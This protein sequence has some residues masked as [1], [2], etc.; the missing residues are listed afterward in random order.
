MAPRERGAIYDEMNR[1]IAA[2]HRVD[3][4]AIG[5][6]DYGKPGNYF[7][8]Q[9]DRWT[10]QYQASETEPS[11]RWT[12]DRMAAATHSAGRARRRI[13]HGDF[14]IDNMIFHPTEPRVLAVLDWELSTLG[15]PLADFAYHL[16]AWRLAP[17]EFRGLRGAD[18]A[19][20]G[21]PTEAEY[22]ATLLRAHRPRAAGSRRLGFLLAFNLFRLAAIL[23]G[24]LARAL[25]GNAASAQ[26][27]ETGR[28]ARPMAELGWKQVAKSRAERDA[29]EAE[30]GHERMTMDFE[31][32]PKVRAL[33]GAPE[34][35]HGRRT[36]IRTSSASRRGRTDAAI[37]GSRRSSSRSSKAKAR[38]AGLVESVPAAVGARRR[39]HQPRIRAAVRDHGP[40]A[41][42]RP[43]SSTARAPDT[44]NMEVLERYGTPEQKAAWLEP[45]LA[46]EIRSA[47]AMTEP[48][49]AS[50]D[51]TNIAGV[52]RAR[53]RRLRDQRPQVVDRRAR[54]DPRCKIFIFMGK[55][56][57]TSAD[58]TRSSR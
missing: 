46:G 28:R 36:S 58:R 11:R 45:L 8:R 4:A 12:A 48:D 31:Y 3:Y 55:T 5:L 47:F 37:A 41:R 44:G 33:A 50:S 30:R 49:V 43:K 26:A 22:V 20:L 7:A 51:A 35:I 1:V 57:P 32:S 34:R 42:G 2:L 15:H 6:A 21:I 16:M 19:A 24:V 54:G 10:E 39:A 9:I 23:Q 29:A 38:A 17:D 14:R 25:A 13:V 27:L 18:L 40:R 56:D 53:R 52:D